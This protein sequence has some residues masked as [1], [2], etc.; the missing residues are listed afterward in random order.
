M[1]DES[2]IRIGNSCKLTYQR[3]FQQRKFDNYVKNCI[4]YINIAI[5]KISQTITQYAP[6]YI[7]FQFI[8]HLNV[9][10]VNHSEYFSCNPY[11]LP[12]SIRT[13]WLEVVFSSKADILKYDRTT[14][15]CVGWVV[16][17]YSV[18]RVTLECLLLMKDAWRYKNVSSR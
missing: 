14:V 11:L 15:F 1:H 7:A 3:F 8:Y 4:I 17:A 13:N 16:V 6:T 9:F 18:R 5:A 10:C 2:T 12:T